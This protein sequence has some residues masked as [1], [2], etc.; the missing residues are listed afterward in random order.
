MYDVPQTTSVWNYRPRGVNRRHRASDYGGAGD[1][2][3]T[4]PATLN[5]ND[6]V[7]LNFTN[8]ERMT[9]S[10]PTVAPPPGDPG[11]F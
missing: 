9:E 1:P 4:G 6:D 8:T 7:W 5:E 10:A 11:K 2:E 3:V